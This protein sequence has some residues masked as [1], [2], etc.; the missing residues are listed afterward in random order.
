MIGRST[1]TTYTCRADLSGPPNREKK[2]RLRIRVKAWWSLKWVRLTA[3]GLAI[4]AVLFSSPSATT[5]SASRGS[6]MPGSAASARPSFRES[7]PGRWSCGAA[8]R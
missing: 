1:R 6:S 7:T 4:P 2:T 3:I 5:T 8:S